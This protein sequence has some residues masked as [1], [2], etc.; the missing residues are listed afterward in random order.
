M[1]HGPPPIYMYIYVT[2]KLYIY[3]ILWVLVLP[4]QSGGVG[5]YICICQYIAFVGRSLDKQCIGFI[6]KKSSGNQYNFS[7]LNLQPIF[8]NSQS[9][10]QIENFAITLLSQLQFAIHNFCN[11]VALSELK[12]SCN[13]Q[14]FCL[15]MQ[16]VLNSFWFQDWQLSII[17]YNNLS[18]QYFLE[19]ILQLYYKYYYLVQSKSL[20]YQLSIQKIYQFSIF[21][22]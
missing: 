4:P 15:N 19:L 6:G 1:Q 8:C 12:F 11:L 2:H 10:S 22:S 3:I 21:Q 16:S 5:H 17:I 20:I 7:Q 14:S 9:Q 18:I 13:I